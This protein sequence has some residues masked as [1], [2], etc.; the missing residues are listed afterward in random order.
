[1]TIHIPFTTYGYLLAPLRLIVNEISKMTRN[2]A[3][4]PT[5][6]NPSLEPSNKLVKSVLLNYSK[7]PTCLS[8]YNYCIKTNV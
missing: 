3:F 1:M 8:L 2:R 6:K 7:L 4:W 5:L